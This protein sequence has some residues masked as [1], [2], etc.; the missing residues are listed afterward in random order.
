MSTG[1]G[2]AIASPVAGARDQGG[3]TL[4]EL[5]VAISILAIIIA[6]LG[7]AVIASLRIV[8]RADER[9]GDSRSALIAA[10]YFANDV[11]SANSITL[12]DPS[13]CGGGTAVVSFAWRDA[14][15]PV[16]AP[17]DR[18][19]SYVI[20]DSDPFDRRLLRRFCAG[21]AAP[22]TS[23]MAI[24]LGASDPVGVTCHRSRPGGTGAL[25]VDRSCGPETRWVKMV[26]TAKPNSP[27]P[28]DPSP[29]PF[30]FTLEGTRRPR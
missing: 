17:V 16:D 12:D 27:T 7:L 9:L 28:D 24:A 2:A 21:G 1:S 3:Y 11:A 29:T 4:V 6:P 18:K 14:S 25:P 15:G 26:V 13:A 22:T 30:S 20:D 5:L 10:A 23:T 19:V 8:G